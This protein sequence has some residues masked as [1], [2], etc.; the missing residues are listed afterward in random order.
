MPDP[1]PI[2]GNRSPHAVIDVAAVVAQTRGT[3]K[4]KEGTTMTQM[5][6]PATQVLTRGRQKKFTPERIQQIKKLVEQG[7]SREKIAELIGVTVGSLQVTCSR[8]G[9]SLRRPKSDTGARLLRREEAP[10][11][12]GIAGDDPSSGD[13]PL[14]LT[15]KQPE[16]SSQPGLLEQA[17]TSTASQEHAKRGNEGTPVNFAIW[18]QYRGQQRTTE[19]A[20]TQQTVRQLAFEAEFRNMRIGE[21]VGEVI[22]AMLRKNLLQAVLKQK[23]PRANSSRGELESESCG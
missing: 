5:A 7:T 3:K 18:M 23:E 19:L 11:S 1:Q 17:Q 14:P 15:K 9:I 22:V 16:E 2:P 21:F 13:M 20:L 8:L 6:D 10:H 4:W 12:R